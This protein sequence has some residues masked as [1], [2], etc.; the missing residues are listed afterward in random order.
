MNWS[1]LHYQNRHLGL[2][3]DWFKHEPTHK[4]MPVLWPEGKRI[5]LWIT[6]PIEFFPLD[7]PV[8]SVRPIGAFDRSYPD[9]F[10][11]S[12]RDYGNRVGIYRLMRVLDERQVRATAAVSAEIAE[13][14]PRI[15]DELLMRNWEIMSAG[16]DMAHI[17]HGDLTIDDE[18]RFIN[19]ARAILET[20]TGKPIIGWHSPG[21]SQSRNTLTLLAENGFQYVADWANDDMP[22]VMKTECGQLYAMPL[23]Y[24][25]SD[26]V[27]LVQNN[28]TVEDYEAQVLEAFQ[29]LDNEAR[30]ANG[31]RIL[32]LSVSPWILGYP[33]RIGTFQRMLDRILEKDSVWPA[34]AAEI[35]EIL[36]KQAFRQKVKNSS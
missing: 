32:S 1:R 6:V 28:L 5:A 20:I 17:H 35:V 2:D 33:H 7:A 34:T 23:T 11:F 16:I 24:E 27:L 15:V 22:Y 13:R 29:Q 21:H 3:H 26:R 12:N 36:N 10:S 4:R 25:W 8:Q 14:Y 19:K 30:L 18:R 9:F 31:A